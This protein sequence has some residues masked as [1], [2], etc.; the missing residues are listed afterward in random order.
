MSR[1]TE[2]RFAPMLIRES[3][4]FDDDG[5]IYELKLDGNRALAYLEED[6]TELRNRKNRDGPVPRAA[7]P[8]CICKEAVRARRRVDRNHGWKA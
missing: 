3:Q 6:R 4:P 2:R 7:R 5:W 8:V 1:F